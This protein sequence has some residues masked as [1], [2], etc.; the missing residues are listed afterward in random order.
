MRKGIPAIFIAQPQGWA[1]KEKI[2]FCVS[3]VVV[4]FFASAIIF[5]RPQR[6]RGAGPYLNKQKKLPFYCVS[7]MSFW[8]IPYKRSYWHIYLSKAEARLPVSQASVPALSLASDSVSE[9]RLSVEIS[10]TFSVCFTR[11]TNLATKIDNLWVSKN[12]YQTKKKYIKLKICT[13][14]LELHKHTSKQNNLGKKNTIKGYLPHHNNFMR[15]WR[16]KKWLKL[17]STQSCQPLMAVAA[18]FAILDANQAINRIQ[19]IR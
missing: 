15:L 3:A 11:S 9:R 5:R 17:R 7:V 4:P 19:E 8:P 1:H 6:Q 16:K 14:R 12:R 13:Y 2:F 10:D 18:V